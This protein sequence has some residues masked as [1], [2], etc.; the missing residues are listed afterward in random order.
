MV[1]FPISIK[2]RVECWTDS[3][4]ELSNWYNYPNGV[5]NLRD[6]NTVPVDGFTFQRTPFGLPAKII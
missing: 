6:D 2:F 3:K 1:L 5:L 4:C